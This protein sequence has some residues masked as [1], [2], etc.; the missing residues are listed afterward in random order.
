MLEEAHELANS[1]LL[2]LVLQAVLRFSTVRMADQIVVIEHG[3][4][5]ERGTHAGLGQ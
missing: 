3:R 1:I 2:L 5:L 4:V